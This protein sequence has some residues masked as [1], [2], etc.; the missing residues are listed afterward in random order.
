M[1]GRPS[2]GSPLR[3][4]PRTGKPLPEGI[5]WREDR[6]RYQIRV[7]VP[8]LYGNWAERTRTFRT[9]TEAKKE[10]A[11]AIAGKNPN[12]AMSLT[13][14]HERHWSAIEASVRPG[15][16]RAYGVAWRKRVKPTLGHMKLE[17]ITSPLIETAMVEWDCSASTKVDALALISRLL[18][19]A[20][21]ARI[22]DYNP[23]REIKR[24]TQEAG[25]APT[26]RALTMPQVTKMLELIPEGVYRRYAA[27]LVFTGMRAG[28]ATA[29]RVRDVD[30]N[31]GVLRVSRSFSPGLNGELIE[32]T[33]KSHKERQ[34][35][36]VKSLL[37]H[38]QEAMKDKEPDDLL[39]SGP[40]GGRLVAANF[41]RAVDWAVIRTAVKR[42]D[43]RVHDLRH[44]FATIL[45]DAGAS[46]PDVQAVLGHSSLQVT[47]R[48]SRAREGVARRTAAVFDRLTNRDGYG[49]NMAQRPDAPRL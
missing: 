40:N 42:P 7:L 15:T 43:L 14:W 25:A 48:Y 30:L 27:A 13:Q 20:R 26:S 12:G 36:I 32:Q 21:R 23:A 9:L 47:E 22:I 31:Q 16:A 24:P 37:P 8:D 29:I 45:F 11:Q 4:D 3:L 39:F 1:A 6:Q 17:A 10:L 18:D 46:A 38:V 49:T 41:R 2:K 19:A 34:V 5:R 44:T 33:P 28:E 35:P